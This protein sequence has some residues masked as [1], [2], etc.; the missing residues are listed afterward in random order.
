MHSSLVKTLI[1]RLKMT[2]NEQIRKGDLLNMWNYQNATQYEGLF[3][4]TDIAC[5]ILLF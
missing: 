5:K 4:L 3:E 2:K 1:F